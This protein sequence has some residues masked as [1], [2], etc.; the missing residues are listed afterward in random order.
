MMSSGAESAASSE[1]ATGMTE[2]T[3]QA[4][5][6]VG[7]TTLDDVSGEAMPKPAE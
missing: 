3:E 5:G 2:A 7:T 6:E 4:S 1:A